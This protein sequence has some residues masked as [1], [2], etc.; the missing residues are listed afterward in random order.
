MDIPPSLLDSPSNALDDTLEHAQNPDD[1][2]RS[3]AEGELKKLQDENF[4]SFLL[5]LSAV[6]ASDKSL[7][8]CRTLAG[9]IIKN[10]VEGKYSE[11][12]SIHIKQWFQLDPLVSLKIKELL[13]VTLGSLDAPARH[14][15]A[16]IIGRLA[17]VEI[18]RGK[19]QDLID[20][21]LGNMA[22]KGASTS[23]MQG[24]LEALEHVFEE[25]LG[26]KQDKIAAVLHAVISA[27]DRAEQRF[28]VR[29]AA[30]KALQQVLKHANFAKE[31]CRSLVMSAILEAADS[32]EA[33][34]IKLEI[35]GCFVVVASRF[36]MFLEPYMETILGLTTESVKGDEKSVPVQCIEFWITMCEKVIELRE[37]RKRFGNATLTADCLFIENQLSSLVSVLLETLLKQERD[38]DAQKISMCSTICLGLIARIL[39]DAIVP[40][41]M[42]FIECNIEMADWQSRKAATCALAVIFQGPSIEKLA[43]VVSLLMDKMED[44]SIEV[45]GTAACTLGRV[46]EHLH[47]PALSNRFFTNEDFPRIM[48]MLS[49]SSKDVPEVCEEACR[50]IYFLA[51]GYE[52]TSNE[53]SISSELSPFLGGVI[54]ALISASEVDKENPFRLPT[55]SSAYEALIEVVTISNVEDVKASIAIRGLMPRFMRRLNTVLDAKAI[56]SSDKSNKYHLQELLSRLLHVIIEKLGNSLYTVSESAQFVLILFCRVLTCDSSAAHDEAA[57]AIGALARALGPKFVDHIRIFLQYY[58]VKLLS[59]V[60]LGV[61]GNMF[62]VLGD[63]ALPYCGYMMNVLYKGFSKRALKPHILACFGEIALATGEDFEEHLKDVMK[64]LEDAAHQRYYRNVFDEDEVDYGNQLRVGILKAYSGILRGIKNPV[65]GCKVA[66]A[67]FEFMQGVTKDQS[68]GSSVSFSASDVLSEFRSMAES[69]ADELIGELTK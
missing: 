25:F 48:T 23:L 50:A 47:S 20:K 9:I 6:L 31:D 29:L 52:S 59:P 60:Y 22:Q 10:S 58:D 57:L 4:P 28:E 26:L 40:L 45:R 27:M 68:R 11:D 30:V 43:P 49:K 33:E 66:A 37:Q 51:R 42:P 34:M 19:W 14:A 1:K 7:P 62:H 69:W 21:L 41:T 18:P 54:D 8:K 65:S 36:Y 3:V 61:I 16:Q 24:T 56:S 32:D 2:I 35:F 64:K 55:S 39:G 17:F 44:P 5:S 12:N 13:L 46:F 53:N 15:S 63:E 67:L 38:D